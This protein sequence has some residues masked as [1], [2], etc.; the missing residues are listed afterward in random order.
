M[1][2]RERGKLVVFVLGGSPG[3]PPSAARAYEKE[4]TRTMARLRVHEIDTQSH[5]THASTDGSMYKRSA[6]TSRS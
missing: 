6:H 2:R 1:K 5:H 3:M 4:S